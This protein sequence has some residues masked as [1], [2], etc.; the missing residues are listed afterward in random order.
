MSSPNYIGVLAGEVLWDRVLPEQ[1][2]LRKPAV[3]LFFD[4]GL[5]ETED[6]LE[7]LVGWSSSAFAEDDA[8]LAI[9]AREGGRLLDADLFGLSKKSL[10]RDC[11]AAKNYWLSQLGV[12]SERTC[13]L[14]NKGMDW[15]LYEEELEDFGVLVLF[16]EHHSVT[17]GSEW[18][19]LLRHFFT[20]FDIESA[21]AK[22]SGSN[23]SGIYTREFLTKLMANY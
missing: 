20:K 21:L 6:F 15:M 2:F 16:T 7:D 11:S 14:F 19:A 4:G 1:V 9:C 17:H 5:L 12:R 10:S 3:S 13:V 18:L 8:V 23:L 22:G